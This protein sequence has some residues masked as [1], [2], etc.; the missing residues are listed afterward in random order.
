MILLADSKDPD[1]TA[2]MQ[3][4]LGLHCPHDQKAYL[5][6]VGLNTHAETLQ[7]NKQ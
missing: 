6:L 5:C 7:I 4:D 2:F 1:Q 3:S